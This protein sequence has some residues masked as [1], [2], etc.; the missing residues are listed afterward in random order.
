[1][2]VTK[3]EL[4]PSEMIKIKP[5]SDVHYG[6]SYCDVSAFREFLQDSDDNTYFIGVG[7]LFDAIIVKDIRYSKCND[8]TKTDAI[9]NEVVFELC[10]I[11]KPYASRIIGLSRGNHEQTVI[12]RCSVDPIDIVCRILNVR[13]LGYSY[14]L[15]LVINNKSVFIR[16]HH[17]WGRGSRTQG[18]DI[19]KFSRDIVHADADIYLFGHVHKLQHDWINQ[20]AIKKNK[21]VSKPKLVCIC[22]SFQKT[23]TT[24]TDAS[25]AE[26]EGYP[27]SVIGG[28]VITIK[29]A[30][31]GLYIS[32][33]INKYSDIF[34][35]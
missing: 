33:S 15:E 17:G 16:G 7:D 19:T 8:A 35:L 2:I 22:G 18:A 26:V 27:P 25:Y 13:Y 32:V 34:V 3:I 12:R 28:L 11:L 30:N 10:D 23:L 14:M 20:L 1:M 6:S 24:T 31:K 5:L 9:I 29:D 21:L 4:N